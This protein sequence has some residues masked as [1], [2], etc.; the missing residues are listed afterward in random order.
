MNISYA[1]TFL[2]YHFSG[3]RSVTEWS[4]SMGYS[5][6][7]FWKRFKS[8]FNVSPQRIYINKKKERLISC[9]ENEVHL[10]NLTLAKKIHLLDE[11]G[12]CQFVKIHFGC[13]P[14]ELKYELSNFR[15]TI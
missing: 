14:S 15:N 8:F 5:R 1:I 13:T 9:L 12:L 3:I 11:N 4:E 6:S 7:Y 10:D 2:D